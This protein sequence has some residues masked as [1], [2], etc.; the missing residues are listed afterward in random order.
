MFAGHNR[1]T[2][3]TNSQCIYS[4]YIQFVYTVCIYNCIYKLAVVLRQDLRQDLYKFRPEIIPEWGLRG[5][6]MKSHGAI[7]NSMF[8]KESQIFFEGVSLG[9]SNIFP[10]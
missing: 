4:L 1:A 7:S 5:V 8:G 6:G 2:V 3:Y 10:W 9:G